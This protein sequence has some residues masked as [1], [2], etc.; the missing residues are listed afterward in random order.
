MSSAANS[1]KLRLWRLA[2]ALLA[3]TALLM[4]VASGASALSLGLQWSGDIVATASEE[5]LE[6][7]QHSGA[8][9]FRVQIDRSN[10]LSFYETLFD[11]AA[12]RGVTILPYLMYG[13]E[14]PLPD[15]NGYGGWGAWVKE[16]VEKYGSGGT[17]WN[18]KSYAKPVTT[19]EIWNEPNLAIYTPA[20][21][22]PE[23][24]VSTAEAQAYGEF[25]RF[26]SY[27]IHEVQ[28]GAQTLVGGLYL[29]AWT[30]PGMEAYVSALYKAPG[31]ASEVGGVGIHPYGFTQGW[32]IAE[33]ANEVINVRTVLNRQSQGSSKPLWITELGWPV[34]ANETQEKEWAPK[35]VNAPTQ[36]TLL[37]QS[38]NWVKGNAGTYNIQ[39]LTWHAARDINKEKWDYHCGLR[40]LSGNYRQSWWEFQQ[41]AGAPIW[42][43]PTNWPY[44]SLGGGLVGDPT[45]SS[46]G[47]GLL[48]VF[49]RGPDNALWHIWYS[50][51]SWSGWQSLGGGITSGPGA[52]SWGPNRID[53]VAR[54]GDN[55][56]WH[57]AWD[58]FGW[59]VE[60]LG[61]S[62]QSAPEISSQGPGQLDVF[63]RGGDNALWHKWYSG[64]GWSGWQSL[65]GSMAGGPGAVSW[66]PNRID[67]VA[68]GGDN[69]V[70]HWAWDG[71]G[72]SL[73]SLGGSVPSDPDIS[74]LGPGYLDVFAKGWD[75]ALWN[76]SY[77]GVWGG[78][79]IVGDGPLISGP[80]AVSWSNTR[81]DVVALKNDSSVRHFFWSP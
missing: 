63:A 9:Y 14:Y 80:G 33:F 44:D 58:G 43:A 20:K 11:R 13:P 30:E 38:F 37:K 67:V 6:V 57:W 56:V 73:G 46:Q 31:I 39:A 54:G 66:G 75:N 78:W 76:D 26:T 71:F 22:E 36:A 35:G 1:I 47:P 60:S 12:K 2:A 27:A 19:W 53:V 4:A 32:Q 15:A 61:G 23:E 7:V 69:A 5:E 62:I 25:F 24:P 49:A 16:T 72:W 74:S 79:H 28:P 34:P 77:G 8:T 51:T 41:Q 10:G 40:D 18:G 64:G 59:S 3:A 70:W 45:I 52:V 55:A 17:F 50:G 48:D 42:P 21:E 81:T 68:R 65:G 29:G